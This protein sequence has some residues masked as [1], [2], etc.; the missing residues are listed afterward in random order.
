MKKFSW[1]V[2]I[3]LLLNP[4]AV[5]AD[6]ASPVSE[7][8]VQYTHSDDIAVVPTK[9]GESLAALITKLERDPRVEFAEPNYKRTVT[10]LPNDTYIGA[11]WYLDT[12]D[13]PEA[14]DLATGTSD[15]VIAVIDTGVL[16]TH[17]DLAANMWDGSACVDENGAPLGGCVHGYDFAGNDTDPTP[18]LTDPVGYHGTHV[19]GIAAATWGNN[20]G[21]AGV[22]PRAKIMAL[23][24]DLDVASEVRAIDFA[25]QNGAKIINASYTG[26]NYSQA[27]YEAIKR[28][29]D[30]GGIFVAA[31]GNEAN[32]N[33]EL[34]LYPANLELPTLLT[35]AATNESDQLASFSNFGGTHVDLGAPGTNIASTYTGPG[36][37]YAYADGTSMASPLVA[38]AAAYL[39]SIA[40]SLS[41]TQVHDFL[42]TYGDPLAALSGKTSTGKRINLYESLV[43]QTAF[44]TPDVAVLQGLPA[45]T[46]STTT[47]MVYVADVDTYRYALDAGEFG[48]T[49]ATTTPITAT[50]TEGPHTLSVIGADRYGNWQHIASS[51]SH[52]WTIALPAPATT[53]ASSTD[54]ATTTEQLLPDTGTTTN[55]ATSTPPADGS[56]Q[57]EQ[58]SSTPPTIEQPTQEPAPT[59][60]PP[61]S[62]GGGGGG[63]GSSAPPPSG[64]GGG[65]ISGGGSG[66]GSVYVPPFAQV[67]TTTATSSST[68][69][70]TTPPTASTTPLSSGDIVNGAVLG[71]STYRF[72]KY[73]VAG[74]RGVEVTELQ[75]LLARLGFFKTEATGY[76][77]AV[78][79]KSVL[80]Y[81]KANKIS[82][83]GTVG[84]LTR[85]SLNRL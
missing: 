72:T 11:Q 16:Y 80:A 65:P 8:I 60:A 24:F 57:A 19:A 66:G 82:Q 48:S 75:N 3:A 33:E 58:A 70:T 35:V 61:A 20:I 77:G 10:A 4:F 1:L 51:T 9:P 38:G 76:F 32:N 36:F 30:A 47:L 49:T 44:V 79:K 14:W 42:T 15:I 6:I 85:A 59:P 54:T 37:M 18:D 63:G 41:A 5:L 53:T 2:I 28:F 81:Q 46:S 56:G 55:A 21:V 78:T 27:E 50:L 26:L 62:G 29:T 40:P 67:A 84:P 12:V 17:E 31:A 69:A 22:A 13:A 23:R 34:P 25:R 45:A 43:A 68:Q 73:L 7:V 39:W 74:S 71:A 52:T 83:V 64:G